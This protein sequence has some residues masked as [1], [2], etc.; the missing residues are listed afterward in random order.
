MNQ[1]EKK[2]QKVLQEVSEFPEIKVLMKEEILIKN[3]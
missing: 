1:K 3:L 2:K